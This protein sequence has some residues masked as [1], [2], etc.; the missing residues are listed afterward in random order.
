MIVFEFVAI[1]AC[2]LF[3]G[4][5]VYINVA[6]HP[7]RMS[8][9]T[10]VAATVFP[11]SY[12][13]ASVMQASLAWVAAASALGAYLSGGGAPWL[14]GGVLI[15]SVVPFTFACI[16]ST[17]NRLKAPDLDREA[18][19]TRMLLVRWG[20][21]HAVRSALGAAASCLL[22]AAGLGG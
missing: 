13:R 21:L 8:A 20:R 19:S 7:A 18:D 3:T 2:I 6:E 15:F 10:A 14:V 9:G 1:L 4:A 17:N 12:A 16:M 5:A 22:L 11:P